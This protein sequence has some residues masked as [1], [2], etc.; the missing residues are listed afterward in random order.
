MCLRPF[1][2]YWPPEMLQDPNL[3]WDGPAEMFS[4]ALVVIEIFKELSKKAEL[5]L[6]FCD[7]AE[8]GTPSVPP[9]LPAM[10][11]QCRS[12]VT[13]TGHDHCC[14]TVT[15]MSQADPTLGSPRASSSS[16]TTA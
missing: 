2:L 16:S 14:C 5:W 12:C 6:N 7:Y 1:P 8:Q 3:P 11:G 15:S 4:F 13:L 10:T 9:L